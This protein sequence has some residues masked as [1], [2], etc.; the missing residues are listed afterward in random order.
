M[1]ND[2]REGEIIGHRLYQSREGMPKSKRIQV[3]LGGGRMGTMK[4]WETYQN[5]VPVAMEEGSSCSISSP[6]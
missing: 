6:A 5:R 3:K 1:G 2:I 4:G